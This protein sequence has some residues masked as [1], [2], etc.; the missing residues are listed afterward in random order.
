MKVKKTRALGLLLVITL[1]VAVLTP[2]VVSAAQVFISDFAGLTAALGSSGSDIEIVVTDRI[3]MTGIIDIPAGKNVSITATSAEVGFIR[4]EGTTGDLITVA[5]GAKLT[6]SDLVIDGNKEVVADAGGSLVRVLNGGEFVL[7]SGAVLQNNRRSSSSSRG[8][9]VY[10]EGIFTMKGGAIKD[11]YSRLC[12]GG[13]YTVGIFEMF[14]GVISGNSTFVGTLD[15]GGHVTVYMCYG[16]GIGIFGAGT[17]E[18]YK[19]T[20]TNNVSSIGAGIYVNYGTTLTIYNA[21][22]TGNT[23]SCFGYGGLGGGLWICGT[24]DA[25]VYD[26]RSAA[27][28]SNSAAESGGQDIYSEAKKNDGIVSLNDTLLGGGE[29]T[30]LDENNGNAPLDTSLGWNTLLK[31]TADISQS[32]QGAA[33]DAATVVITNNTGYCGAAMGINGVVYFGETPP[34]TIDLV[35]KKAWVGDNSEPLL[36]ITVYLVI[37]GEKQENKSITLNAGNGWQ[38][39]FSDL[40]YKVRGKVVRYTVEEDVPQGY[41]VKYEGPFINLDGQYEILIT[42]TYGLATLILEGTKTLTTADGVAV[43]VKA[44]EFV[45]VLTPGENNP[46]G[47]CSW[48]GSN[49][50]AVSAEGTVNFGTLTFSKAGTYVFAISEEDLGAKEIVYDQND[51]TVTVVVEKDGGRLKIVSVTYSKSGEEI[52]GIRF[53][54]QFEKVVL[55]E[56]RPETG[57]GDE[58]IL[59]ISLMVLSMIGCFGLAAAGFR[60]KKEN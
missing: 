26:F 51:V 7:E 37:N 48:N 33:Q 44:G 13:I 35:V 40:P 2:T 17:A 60:R 59:W 46:A 57:D 25:A 56:H 49:P 42:N 18:I 4:G 30:W 6:L 20:I 19:G 36:D 55:D 43:P 38:S 10:N 11:N 8:G 5:A 24:G 1:L 14:D 41:E 45:F 31:L 52:N 47:G 53:A 32:D 34:E 28:Y 21:L 54:N 50:T 29:V 23:A 15:E 22:I 39:T 27:I 12:G 58:P 3:V 16:G 9:G